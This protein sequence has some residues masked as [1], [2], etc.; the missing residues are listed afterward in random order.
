MAPMMQPMSSG[1]NRNQWFRQ[2]RLYA[3][4]IVTRSFHDSTDYEGNIYTKGGWV[5]KM[6]REKLGDQNFFH[7]LHYYLETNRGQNV[8]TADLQKSIE[9]ATSAD[10]DQ[11]FDQWVYRAGAP[12]YNVNYA[13]DRDQPPGEARREAD[14]KSGRTRRIV[15]R[16]GGSGNRHRKR[17]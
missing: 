1:E 8:V 13:Y 4:P 9:Q 3:V 14:P 12:A 17:P 15:R 16:S 11:F 5:L 7:A 2:K 6:L 10:V